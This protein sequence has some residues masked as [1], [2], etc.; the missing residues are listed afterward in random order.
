MSLYNI[1]KDKTVG[2]AIDSVEV[3]P[4]QYSLIFNLVGGGKA[5]Y[6][7]EGDCCSRS[8]IEHITVPPDIKGAVIFDVDDSDAVG[9]SDIEDDDYTV[10]RV[11]GTAFKTPKGEV[12]V[13]YRNES[14]GYYGGWMYGPQLVGVPVD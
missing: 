1:D 14:N 5:I 10:T 8:W 11:Y 9:D 3:A 13:E 2:L 4:D 7:V 6:G 12:I